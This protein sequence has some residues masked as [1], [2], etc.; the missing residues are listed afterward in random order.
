MGDHNCSP[1]IENTSNLYMYHCNLSTRPLISTYV[2]ICIFADL[3]I[4]NIKCIIK[5]VTII[6]FV[7]INSLY[8][9]MQIKHSCTVAP[10]EAPTFS[11]SVADSRTV[12][13]S[14]SH[15]LTN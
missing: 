11:A 14:M 8:Y 6:D 13:G 2:R 7:S 9:E 10:K 3:T 1:K 12:C 15:N 5:L 4:S